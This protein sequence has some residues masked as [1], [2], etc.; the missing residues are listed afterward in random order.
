ML[1][2]I[3]SPANPGPLAYVDRGGKRSVKMVSC[4]IR[5]EKLDE[6]IESLNKLNLVGGMMIADVR[7]LGSRESGSELYRGPKYVMS[8]V[9]KVKIELVIEADD[10]KQ[11]EELISELA[12]TGELGDGKIFILN[13]VDLL[14]IRTGEKGVSAL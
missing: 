12:R 13:V 5:I 11:V 3:E 8:F 6:V 1:A 2:M 14:R 10:V 9:P 7:G 4:V